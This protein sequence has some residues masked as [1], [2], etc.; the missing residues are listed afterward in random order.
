ME[1]H[2]DNSAVRAVIAR[3]G[4]GRVKHLST[5][6]LWMQQAVRAGIVS[7]HRVASDDNP[8]DLGTKSLSRLRLDKL[9]ERVGLRFPIGRC[10]AVTQQEQQT[11]TI[12]IEAVTRNNLLLALL[13]SPNVGLTLAE[14]C[15]AEGRFGAHDRGA[16]FKDMDNTQL[17]GMCFLLILALLVGM[18]LGSLMVFYFWRAELCQPRIPP[19]AERPAPV[20]RDCRRASANK[21][22]SREAALAEGAQPPRLRAR[23]RS[24]SWRSE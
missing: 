22:A 7:V 14:G 18:G 2:V 23:L 12:C 9:R 1:L 4:V 15:S 11:R 5:E 3:E 10:A 17:Y 13:A 24:W 19:V 8:A 21:R 20:E 16:G 6:A